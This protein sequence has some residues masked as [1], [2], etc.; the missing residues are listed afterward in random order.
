MQGFG[1]LFG[2]ARVRWLLSVTSTTVLAAGSLASSYDG[3]DG[4]EYCDVDDS[5][6]M[7]QVVS[8][9]THRQ[10]RRGEPADMQLLRVP[11]TGAAV[12]NEH[13]CK[14]FASELQKVYKCASM[15]DW[16]A[17]KD[18]T[19]IAV[20]LRHPVERTM[21][22]FFHLSNKTAFLDS[23]QSFDVPE[24]MKAA[25]RGATQA[26][27][28]GE[29]LSLPMNP[30]RNRQTLSL[31]GLMKGTPVKLSSGRTVSM[32]DGIDWDRDGN[33]IVELAK[34]HLASDRVTFG[35]AEDYDCAIR[36]FANA[37]GWNAS[38]A[39]ARFNSAPKHRLSSKGGLIASLAQR[40]DQD[41]LPPLNMAPTGN[42]WA[43]YLD[44]QTVKALF[45]ANMYDM[46]LYAYAQLL[47]EPRAQAAGC[48]HH[49]RKAVADPKGKGD[50]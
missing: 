43:Q 26:R 38:R 9:V 6:A 30:M 18:A 19:A 44:A 24:L 16:T 39:E 25:I 34:E 14:P 22:E 32:K 28:L 8:Q 35:F 2:P 13:I 11:R 45:Q 33:E 50:L 23:W 42:S 1:H 40:T 48:H 31:S 7:L 15:S 5:V 46:Q 41:A 10:E 17:V 47:M 21:S 49:T 36:L 4:L 29:Y 27:D 37:F 12:L 3:C 20:L